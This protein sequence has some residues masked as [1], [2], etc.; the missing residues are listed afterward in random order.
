MECLLNES[1]RGKGK[2]RK[3]GVN[4]WK[5]KG[6]EGGSEWMEEERKEGVN[7]WKRKGRS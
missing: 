1:R 2:E 5:R 6:K 7:G 4:G 3:E